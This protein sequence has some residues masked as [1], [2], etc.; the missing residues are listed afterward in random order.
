MKPL[1]FKEQGGAG[2]QGIKVSCGKNQGRSK[3]RLDIWFL[4]ALYCG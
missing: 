1:L 3:K 2:F 4:I